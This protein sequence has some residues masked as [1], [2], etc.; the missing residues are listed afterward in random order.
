MTCHG[1][2]IDRSHALRGNA[3]LGA[4][5]PRVTRSVTRCVPT[6]SE[7]TIGRGADVEGFQWRKA[8]ELNRAVAGGVRTGGQP[9]Q[10]ITNRQV[11]RQAVLVV[12]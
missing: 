3:A 2:F 10:P 12:L 7:G 8:I 6:R 5:R 1:F 11:Q 9:V 4:L